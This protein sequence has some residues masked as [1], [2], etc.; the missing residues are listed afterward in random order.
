MKKFLWLLL[1]ATSAFAATPSFQETTNI[2]IAPDIAG[3]VIYVSPWGN[4]A[5]AD[6]SYYKPY[7]NVHNPIEVY[8]DGTPTWSGA[9]KIAQAGDTI[10]LTPD[11]HYLGVIPLKDNVNLLIS[12]GAVV[13]RSAFFSNAVVAGTP[14]ELAADLNSAGPLIQPGSNSTVTAWGATIITTNGT[15]Q[16]GY[17]W[18][19][20]LET[21][22]E[23]TF[24][25]F[26]NRSTINSA[27]YGGRF[28]GPSDNLYFNQTA[29]ALRTARVIESQMRNG[30]DAIRANGNLDLRTF[31]L[32]ASSTNTVS[33]GGD[34][35]RGAVISGGTKWT[36]NNSSILVGGGDVDNQGVAASGAG[37]EAILN[38]TSIH[39]YGSGEG[40]DTSGGATVAGVYSVNEVLV[41][42]GGDSLFFL[43]PTSG[44]D[45]VDVIVPSDSV[46]AIGTTVASPTDFI[47]VSALDLKLYASGADLHLT[48]GGNLAT[49][50]ANL[51][52]NPLAGAGDKMLYIKNSGDVDYAGHDNSPGYPNDIP[53]TV[54]T[55]TIDLKVTGDTALLTVPTGKNY[56]LT[57]VTVRIVSSDSPNGD[58]DIKIKCTEG[59]IVNSLLVGALSVSEAT[60]SAPSIPF[61]IALAG[62]LIEVEVLTPESGTTL[63]GRVSITGY[64]VDEP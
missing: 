45:G 19:E 35:S 47:V 51:K 14:I 27:L 12:P 61:K 59:D 43:D 17:G 13:Y 2:V 52:I 28:V 8:R 7:K 64:Y 15:Y 6:G 36:D 48:M 50:A 10:I 4:D 54:S 41:G 32:F 18:F 9:N 38:F 56:I 34:Q 49:F 22:G 37:T 25:S 11:V 42:G 58:A 62:S 3:K 21:W 29:T 44:P 5:T 63:T 60:Q 26:T 16:A 39:Y 33:T 23:F 53:F 31:Q 1:S 30:W 55:T 24:L 20:G 40:V 46:K 57:S